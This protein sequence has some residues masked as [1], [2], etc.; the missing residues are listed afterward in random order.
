MHK[1][2][3]PLISF[4]EDYQ[5]GKFTKCEITRRLTRMKDLVDDKPIAKSKAATRSRYTVA[6]RNLCNIRDK[7]GRPVYYLCIL[8]SSV[9]ALHQ[10][11]RTGF[12]DALEKWA[13][14]TNFPVAFAQ[15]VQ[16]AVEEFLASPATNTT[17]RV[18]KHR[19]E[20][21][22]SE[23]QCFIPE[24]QKTLKRPRI[25]EE[26]EDPAQPDVPASSQY[27]AQ[28]GHF[29]WI[30][31][32]IP[33]A[34]LQKTG[35][36]SSPTQPQ[37]MSAAVVTPKTFAD[38]I[39]GNAPDLAYHAAITED[40]DKVD[41]DVP[42]FNISSD[43]CPYVVLQ[44]DGMILSHAY[45]VSRLDAMRALLAPDIVEDEIRVTIPTIEGARPFLTF[46]CSPE[47]AL[48]L[49]AR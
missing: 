36:Q 49:T 35:P 40:C 32:Q 8:A 33:F 20:T 47:T 16:C 3:A 46:Y 27:N 24:H 31:D 9:K 25:A 42:S 43:H 14:E 41:E 11:D 2:L 5:N 10:Y 39:I 4:L 23:R 7:L 34:T 38:P 30:N 6:Q 26:K 13:E 19:R 45:Q 44:N 22:D 18:L 17:A 12:Q 15:K 48:R 28:E 29:I 37:S 21:D 1:H